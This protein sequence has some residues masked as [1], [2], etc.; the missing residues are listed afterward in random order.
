MTQGRQNAIGDRVVRPTVV[1]LIA[2]VATST[3]WTIRPPQLRIDW[4]HLGSWL[5]GSEPL[6]ALLAII[7][8]GALLVGGYLTL[9]SG[10][11]LVAAVTQAAR[12]RRLARAVAVPPVRRF[13]DAVLASSIMVAAVT[14]PRT[15]VASTGPAAAATIAWGMEGAGSAD[16]WASAPAIDIGSALEPSRPSPTPDLGGP[17]LS[18]ASPTSTAA[19]EVWDVARVRLVAAFGPGQSADRVLATESAPSAA[20]IEPNPVEG[21]EEVPIKPNDRVWRLVAER[22][23]GLSNARIAEVVRAIEA[24]NMG[25]PQPSY[26][27]FEDVDETHPGWSLLFPRYVTP[28]VGD[29]IPSAEAQ[30]IPAGHAQAGSTALA[31]SPA[32]PRDSDAVGEDGPPSAAS[33]VNHRTA[34][35]DGQCDQTMTTVGGQ[36]GPAG[37]PAAVTTTTTAPNEASSTQPSDNGG[38]V[39]GSATSERIRVP[40]ADVGLHVAI[41]VVATLAIVRLNRRRAHR[42][43]RPRPGLS[44]EPP[45]RDPLPALV[46]AVAAESVPSEGGKAPSRGLRGAHRVVGEEADTVACGLVVARLL[47]STADDL[48]VLVEHDTAQ[49]VF[50]ATDGFPGFEVLPTL[51]AVLDEAEIERARRSRILGDSTSIAEY[52]ARDGDELLA[53]VL[54]VGSPSTSDAGRWKA[55]AEA[56]GRLGIDLLMIDGPSAAGSTLQVDGNGVVRAAEDPALLGVEL[57]RLGPT[58]ASVIMEEVAAARRGPD[59]VET[60]EP[61]VEVSFAFEVLDATSP[62]GTTKP[63]TVQL[64]GPVIATAQARSTSGA[65]REQGRDLFVYLALHPGPQRRDAIIDELWPDADFE[66]GKF[67]FHYAVKSLRED[68]RVVLDRD[69]VAVVETASVESD[70]NSGAVYQLQPGLFDTDLWRFKRALRAAEEAADPVERRESYAQAMESYGGEFVDG[71]EA[72]WIIREREWLRGKAVDV[73]AAIADMEAE[74]GNPEGALAAVRRGIEADPYAEDLYVRGVQLLAGLGRIDAA[75]KL[76]SD[77]QRQLED[78]GAPMTTSR[79]AVSRAISDA[80]RRRSAREALQRKHEPA[81]ADGTGAATA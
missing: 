3:L 72:H 65:I 27:A 49:R 66:K 25:R 60:A 51:A 44:A 37:Q 24:K 5:D 67:K 32:A 12:W 4:A 10:T 28:V 30:V 80:E 81:S 41:G 34:S 20:T 21:W 71:A 45:L 39:D 79:E 63:V 78:L 73:A 76:A 68:V 62:P 11:Y 29:P 77:L 31:P 61:P 53:D 64:F 58:A 2:V 15:T 54:V 36:E 1:F 55:L 17:S 50:G 26:G 40:D 19:S 14:A 42:A 48:R 38:D 69:D 46:A 8:T 9:V 59:A 16:G 75:R 23:P 47:A 56:G 33:D 43:R 13:M 70:R 18:P 7:R 22:W 57:D 52:R 74:A 6:W 35:A